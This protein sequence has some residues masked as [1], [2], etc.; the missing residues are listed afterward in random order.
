MGFWSYEL[1]SCAVTG[2]KWIDERRMA[3]WDGCRV[4]GGAGYAPPG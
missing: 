3:M 2:P 1:E 4:I